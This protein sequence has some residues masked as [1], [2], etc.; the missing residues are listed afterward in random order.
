MQERYPVKRRA[1]ISAAAAIYAAAARWITHP[2]HQPA[3]EAQGGEVVGLSLQKVGHGVDAGQHHHCSGQQGRREG[4]EGQMAAAGATLPL[5]RRGMPA[6]ALRWR[7]P[8]L[9]Q[10]YWPR[11]AI[12]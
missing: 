5:P 10:D 4:R 3:G 8:A 2:L 12:R 9:L 1:P 6:P 7:P 11:N